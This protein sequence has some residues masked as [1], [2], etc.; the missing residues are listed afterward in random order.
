MRLWGWWRSPNGKAAKARDAEQLLR[1]TRRQTPH[2]RRVAET[3][4]DLPAE[5]LAER[6]RRAMVRRA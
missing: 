5:E 6:M 2:V 3:L 4:A 1:A